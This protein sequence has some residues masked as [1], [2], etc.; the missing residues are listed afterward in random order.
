MFNYELETHGYKYDYNCLNH[1]YC[2][3]F[4]CYRL[5]MSWRITN[6]QFW[7]EYV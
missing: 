5:A 1:I 2:D 4:I 3:K 7:R 6:I